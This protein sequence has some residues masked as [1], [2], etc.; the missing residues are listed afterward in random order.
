MTV[1]VSPPFGIPER[2]IPKVNTSFPADI[3]ILLGV[4]LLRVATP[5][6]MV[7][8]KSVSSKSPLPPIALNAA[9]EKVTVIVLLS[10]A[11]DTDEIMGPALSYRETTLLLCV[12]LATLSPPS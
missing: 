1:R 2:G 10:A 8:E 12:V 9:S 3:E 7:K 6:L 5:P 11:K 4:E